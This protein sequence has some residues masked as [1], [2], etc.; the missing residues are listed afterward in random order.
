[1]L[2]SSSNAT[3]TINDDVIEPSTNPADDPTEFVRQHYHDF[4]NRE[5]DQNGLAFWINEI[6]SCGTDA[7]CIAVKRV[8]VSAAFYLSIEFQ[9]TGY[10]VE[11][12]YKA[13][14]GDAIGTSTVGGMHQ[15][16]VPIVRLNEFLSDTQEIGLGVVVNQG[17]WRQLLEN[18][19]QAF[20][21]EFVRRQK[22]VSAF[23][24]TWT[25]AQ[26]VDKLFQNAVVTPSAT[27]RDTA[28]GRFGSASDTTNLTARSQALRDVAEN[29]IFNQQ[30]FNR[31]FVLMQYLGYLRRNPDDAPDSDYTGFE[32]WLQKLNQFDGNYQN[33]EMV[34]AF[35]TSIEYR[36]RFGQ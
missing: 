35:I 5:P 11:R 36:Q 2:S 3:V 1:V 12:I 14:Y 8:N 10:L 15:L 23:P 21:A 6:T 30:E 13:S 7:Q 26:F 4:L 24:T 18:N 9:G 25:P 34:K 27:D 22:F 17:D 33:A 16:P 20:C 31:G 28:I 29:S 19:K 32:F